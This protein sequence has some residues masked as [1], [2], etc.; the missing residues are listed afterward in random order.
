MQDFNHHLSN[1]WVTSIA[2]VIIHLTVMICVISCNF[3][4]FSCVYF[5]YC[6]CSSLVCYNLFCFEAVVY[7]FLYAS[8]LCSFPQHVRFSSQ[9]WFVSTVSC[10][11]SLSFA[12]KSVCFSLSWLNGHV[13]LFTFEAAF[14]CSCMTVLRILFVFLDFTSVCLDLFVLVSL[15]SGFDPCLPHLTMNLV[16]SLN[17]KLL[18]YWLRCL[19]L[20][21]NT[22]A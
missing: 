3:F 15:I 21:P 5:L 19:R 7:V 16:F 12:F 13:T 1:L 9:A 14:L 2:A 10:Y 8:S 11:F 17:N 22:L 20:S 4:L 18:K 6:G